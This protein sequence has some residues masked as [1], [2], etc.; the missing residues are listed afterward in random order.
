MADQ[1]D[2]QL[3]QSSVSTFL[4]NEASAAPVGIQNKYIGPYRTLFFNANDSGNG[5]V[6]DALFTFANDAART[7][8]VQQIPVII[9]TGFAFAGFIPALAPYL[10]IGVTNTVPAGG[11]LFTGSVLPLL[12]DPPTMG[13]FLP[14]TLI[15]A[16]EQAMNHN[17]F[18]N[19]G[20]TFYT[21]GPARLTLRS[22][23]HMVT[24]DLQ[25]MASN[26]VFSTDKRYQTAERDH[27]QSFE[28]T[29]PYK[30]VRL[31][32]TNNEAFQQ[33]TFDATLET[34]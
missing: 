9:G 30:P 33:I 15:S 23:G 20:A 34:L 12:S 2:W 31:Q 22:T 10:T 29:L 11:Q 25:S 5:D 6:W 1:P 7:Q 18:S 19:I 27:T 4:Y 16:V 13:R 14:R 8:I 3:Y 24:Y 21:A 26:G 17:N 32:V 28:V